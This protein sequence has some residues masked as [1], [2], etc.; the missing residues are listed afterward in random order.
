VLAV[1]AGST[2]SLDLPFGPL[3]DMEFPN[4]DLARDTVRELI[5]TGGRHKFTGLVPVVHPLAN[6]GTPTFGNTAFTMM[7]QPKDTIYPDNRRHHYF[8]F[9][10]SFY[11]KIAAKNTYQFSVSVSNSYNNTGIPLQNITHSNALSTYI[12]DLQG[13][14]LDL[15]TLTQNGFNYT[16]AT[17]NVQLCQ[18][19]YLVVQNGVELYMAPNNGLNFSTNNYTWQCNN[20]SFPDY[21]DLTLSSSCSYYKG[22]AGSQAMLNPIFK[23]QQNKEMVFSAWVRESCG[24]IATG[25]PCKKYTYSN[26]QVHLVYRSGVDSILALNP[27]GPIIDGWQRY[28]AVFTVPTGINQLILRLLNTGTERMYFDDIRI[29]PFNAN[30]RSYVYHPVNLRLT[31]E[32]DENNYA[33]FYEY[34]EE[35]VLVRTKV[36]TREGIKTVSETRSAIQSKIK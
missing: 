36:E 11:I 20:S 21:R 34:D 5:N 33:R 9:S 24:N 25:V 1:D 26:N 12:Y 18:G 10:D 31:S 17:Y 27:T 8:S 22:I 6:Q 15:F 19:T 29:H 32:L 2:A 16:S 7:I 3:N 30:V 13:N 4:L 14:M 28:E 35:G 23:V